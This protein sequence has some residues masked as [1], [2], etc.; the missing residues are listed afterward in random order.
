MA[1]RFSV[2]GGYPQLR[3]LFTHIRNPQNILEEKYN[4]AHMLLQEALLKD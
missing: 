2:D 3:Y 1:G 4:R